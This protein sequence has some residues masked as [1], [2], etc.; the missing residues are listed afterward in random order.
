MSGLLADTLQISGKTGFYKGREVPKS[1]VSRPLKK[2]E[3]T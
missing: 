3:G 1:P 2:K